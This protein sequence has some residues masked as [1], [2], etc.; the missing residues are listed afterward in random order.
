MGVVAVIIFAITNDFKHF[1][2]GGFS[3][4]VVV[5]VLMFLFVPESPRYYV[6]IGKNKK[7]LEVY[8]YLAKLHPDED[9]KRKIAL[10]EVKVKQGEILKDD[11]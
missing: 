1:M 7:A 6:A 5:M 4:G 2:I 9:V 3:F 11:E 10:L 8:K